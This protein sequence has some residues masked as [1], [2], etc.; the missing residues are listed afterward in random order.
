MERDK[1]PK[2]Y[3]HSQLQGNITEEQP[4]QMAHHSRILTRYQK[5]LVKELKQKC[6]GRTRER[7][8]MLK[9]SNRKQKYTQENM[10]VGKCM[11][12]QAPRVATDKN[13]KILVEFAG[14][15]EECEVDQGARLPGRCVGQPGLYLFIF[16]KDIPG[17]F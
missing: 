9:E 8:F 11:T 17:L 6:T 16:S 15:T 3:V 12:V 4:L 13:D 2:H 7:L 14:I 10:R 5:K 1:S